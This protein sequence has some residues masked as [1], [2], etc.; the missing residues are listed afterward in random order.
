MAEQEVIKHTK[1]IYKVWNSK[2][3]SFW[4][5]VKEFVLEILII[6]FAVTLS[7]W[8]HG[9]SEHAHQQKDVKDFLLGLQADL[10]ND[11]SEMNADRERFVLS[12]KAY[13]Y[14][15]NLKLNE[16]ISKDSLKIYDEVLFNSTGLIPND[17][18]FEGFK[19]AGKIG[20]IENK[21]LQNEIMD[22]YQENIPFVIAL[23][24][25]YNVE[26]QKSKDYIN[27]NLKRN[28]DSTNNFIALLKTE[29][30]Y[31]VGAELRDTKAIV[32][33]YNAC[34]KN[35]DRI[36]KLIDEEYKK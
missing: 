4:A 13:S 25:Y 22:L 8:L 28:T 11:R 34:I 35:I 6:V 23:T 36:N 29:E 14:L 17:G 33:Q 26:K 18:R 24:N 7:I 20:T 9:Q 16:A 31:N 10:K 15:R 32:A 3:H 30:V 19:S 5:K 27:K 1:K 2:E 21:K 12:G